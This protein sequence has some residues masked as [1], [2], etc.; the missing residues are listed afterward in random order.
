VGYRVS[1]GHGGEGAAGTSCG[2]WVLPCSLPSLHFHVR[3]STNISLPFPTRR[4][5]AR[6]DPPYVTRIPFFIL[7][8]FSYSPRP[9]SAGLT[10]P[11]IHRHTSYVNT[12][13]TRL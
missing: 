5:S 6:P 1:D 13:A 9:S 3:K 11:S 10:K 8:P 7:S 4:I 12:N 2:L